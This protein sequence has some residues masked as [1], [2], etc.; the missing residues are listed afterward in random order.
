MFRR[1]RELYGDG[2]GREDLIAK[3]VEY[4]YEQGY[5]DSMGNRESLLTIERR[6]GPDEMIKRGR[7]WY[8]DG[9]RR[10]EL[11]ARE[12]EYGWREGY[13]GDFGYGYDDRGQQRHGYEPGFMGGGELLYGDEEDY[14]ERRYER[15]EFSVERDMDRMALRDERVCCY[16]FF[17]LSRQF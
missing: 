15:D 8:G 14:E 16:I 9:L 1:G 10:N 13:Y 11:L 7:E 17:F 2:L 12:A 5:A 3:E 6:F 4:V